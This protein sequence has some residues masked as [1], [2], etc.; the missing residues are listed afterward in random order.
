MAAA[1]P[2][3]HR[4]DT[5]AAEAAAR[6]TDGETSATA[7]QIR[8]SPPHPAVAVAA[9]TASAQTASRA[10][11]RV[12]SIPERAALRQRLPPPGLPRH[13]EEHRT[14]YVPAP[15]AS[16]PAA[17]QRVPPNHRDRAHERFPL[18]PDAAQGWAAAL[19]R[20]FVR[21]ELRVSGRADADGERGAR[22]RTML[23]GRTWINPASLLLLLPIYNRNNNSNRVSKLHTPEIFAV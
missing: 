22:F 16:S 20:R 4:P 8:T 11:A 12:P 9:I 15:S 10:A 7:A 17:Q 14:A 5:E 1:H 21:R 19:L 2:A 13:R 18:A 3:L 23:T 6:T